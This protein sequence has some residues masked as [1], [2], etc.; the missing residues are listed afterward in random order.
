MRLCAAAILGP[1]NVDC[2]TED[3]SSL[4]VLECGLCN[5]LGTSSLF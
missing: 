1:S 3:L 4:A 5:V 2:T